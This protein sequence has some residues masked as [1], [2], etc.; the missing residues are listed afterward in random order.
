MDVVRRGDV[1]GGLFV[2]V[3]VGLFSW[4]ELILISPRRIISRQV[5]KPIGNNSI[6]RERLVILDPESGEEPPVMDA[7]TP[8]PLEMERRPAESFSIHTLALVVAR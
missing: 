4:G 2:H 3:L 1:L 8:S 6:E 5:C 7:G